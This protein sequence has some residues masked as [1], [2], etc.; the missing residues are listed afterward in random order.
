MKRNDP[1]VF[2]KDSLEQV[3][4]QFTHWRTTREKRSRIPDSLWALIPPLMNQYSHNKIASALRLNAAQLK[5]NVLPLLAKSPSAFIECTIPPL[6]PLSPLEST[7]VIEFS[8]H[9][10]VRIKI[11]GLSCNHIESLIANLMRE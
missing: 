7:P 1:A 10:G 3:A 9:N 2:S 4:Q 8:R 6:P 5:E 11:T